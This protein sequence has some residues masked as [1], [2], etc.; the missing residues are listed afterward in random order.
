MH[1]KVKGQVMGVSA[2]RDSVGISQRPPPN[3]LLRALILLLF[4]VSFFGADAFAISQLMALHGK[5]SSSGTSIAS[6]DLRVFIY[7][8]PS[9]GNLVYDSS[10]DF[11]GMIKS[12]IFDV[13]LG[14]G[15]V[16]L[17]LNYGA[18]YYMD[19]AVNGSDLDFNGAERKQF[20]ASRGKVK[21]ASI[22]NETIVN[23]NISPSAAID[24]PKISKAG[25]TIT[26]FG[27]SADFNN[28]YYT[29]ADANN[30]LLK[31]PMQMPCMQ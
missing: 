17:D 21:S 22:A 12:G 14:S 24:W 27:L 15:S 2:I 6:G 25:A 19:I 7:D 29:Q 8:D 13:M 10:S 11:N 23:A 4:L 1:F 16:Q 28:M 9:A 20:E 3:S 5:A 30:A 18:Y 31:R 26:D